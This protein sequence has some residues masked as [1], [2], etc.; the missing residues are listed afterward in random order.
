MRTG[1]AIA[2]VLASFQPMP[3]QPPSAANDAHV[4]RTPPARL[5][6]ILAWPT[7]APPHSTRFARVGWAPPTIDHLYPI[8]IGVPST[9][10]EFPIRRGVCPARHRPWSLDAVGWA[11]PTPSHRIAGQQPCE[12]RTHKHK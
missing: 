3:S 12:P 5:R 1:S 2:T 10:Y 9:P 7:I 4:P 11:M 8:G 6:C